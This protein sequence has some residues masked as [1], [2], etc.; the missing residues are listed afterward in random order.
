M[1]T[2]D[3]DIQCA[4][5]LAQAHKRREGMIRPAIDLFENAHS[6]EERAECARYLIG[7]TEQAEIDFVEHMAKVASRI[8]GER[9]ALVALGKELRA[10]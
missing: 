10:R 6:P 9:Q 1:K 8:K 7:V 4:K 2:E 3:T 5:G